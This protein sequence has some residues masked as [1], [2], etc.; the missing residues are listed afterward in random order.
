M[1][2]VAIEAPRRASHVCN[3]M[4]SVPPASDYEYTT[5][6]PITVAIAHDHGMGAPS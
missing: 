5:F 4:R 6:S 3:V 2:A 1:R